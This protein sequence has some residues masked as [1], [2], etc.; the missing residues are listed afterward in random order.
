M[1]KL[2]FIIIFLFVMST[3]I[4]AQTY[5][6][7]NS[8]NSKLP[9]N[10]LYCIDFDNDG[11]TW[12]GGQRNAA[13]GIANVSMLTADLQ[14]WK[15]YDQAELALPEDRVFYAAIDDQNT[16]WFCTH[17][18]VSALM[19]DGTAK[20]ID[21][22]NDKYTRTVQTDSKGTVYI[23]IRE[24]NRVDSRIHLSSDHGTTWT[25]WKCADLGFS[26]DESGGRPE[27]YDLREDSKGQLWVCTWY[28]VTYRKADNTWKSI[29]PLELEYT[30]AMTLDSQDHVWV[31]IDGKKILHE[32]MPDESIFTHDSTTIMPLKY[33]VQD[34]EADK[35][36][37]IWCALEGGGLLEILPD[38]S[39]KQYTSASTAGALPEDM[40]T[41]L[42]I[43]DNIIW[44]STAT[45]GVVRIEGLIQTTSVPEPEITPSPDFQLFTNY[46][47][48]FNPSTNIRF[49]LKNSSE[50]TLA[51][52]NLRGEQ[53]KVLASGYH[54][55]GTHLVSWDGKNFNGESVASGIYIYRLTSQGLN[56]SQKMLLVK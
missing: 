22:T 54:S 31:P 26:F 50:I 43:K 34:L 30:Y 12:F 56:I 39:F 42:E 20:L 46:P 28:G 48:P 14:T 45:K 19:A 55:A 35:N 17:Y 16:K 41:L 47:N 10:V 25:T 29:A 4:G 3:I 40:L 52:Y 37:H 32:I 21:F 24:D 7:F 8:E 36:G 38:K 53:M 11:N 27:I 33:D 49:E 13:T 6:V 5:T 23:S 1:K 51:V 9:Y 44:V 15:V 18:G 2:Q